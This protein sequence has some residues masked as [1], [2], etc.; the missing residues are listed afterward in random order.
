[1]K[2]FVRVRCCVT[3]RDLALLSITRSNAAEH[4]QLWQDVVKTTPAVGADMAL[5]LAGMAAW[6]SGDGASATIALGRAL[7]TA[8]PSSNPHPVR[9]LDGIIDQVVPPDAWDSIRPALLAD[10][11]AA[12]GRA[13]RAGRDN[14]AR[15][16]GWPP[17]TRAQE[18]VRR[19]EVDPT[20]PPAPG[21]AI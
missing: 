7:E 19:P 11:P 14:T 12:V 17:V 15:R 10:V 20:K 4:L 9:L 16:D 2:T 6:I 3:A 18:P 21:I 5:Y 8:P 1:M 13:L